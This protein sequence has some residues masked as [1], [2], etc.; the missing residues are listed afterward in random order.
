MGAFESSNAPAYPSAIG[1]T[2]T[3]SVNLLSARTSHSNCLNWIFWPRNRD[4][5]G[6]FGFRVGKVL[7]AF[8]YTWIHGNHHSH[9][10]F[11]TPFGSRESLFCSF[12]ICTIFAESRTNAFLFVQRH[13]DIQPTLLYPL[14]HSKRELW[15]HA[16]GPA[17]YAKSGPSKI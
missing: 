9:F 17:K 13:L 11:F 15:D 2:Q 8:A 14:R 12:S 3:G 5:T 4:P 6:I 10:Y 7:L 1:E 16:Q